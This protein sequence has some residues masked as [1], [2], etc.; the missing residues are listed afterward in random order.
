M[1]LQYIDSPLAQSGLEQCKNHSE[2]YCNQLKDLRIIVVSP[3][4]RALQ[5]AFYV[6]GQHPR[7]QDI[8]VIID[9]Y[10]REG[11]HWTCGIPSALQEKIKFAK[12]LFCEFKEVN[13]DMIDKLSSQV[14]NGNPN[15]W[16][17]ETMVEEDK[18]KAYDFINQNGQENYA[19][20]IR[21]FIIDKD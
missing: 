4:H 20:M 13:T 11:M 10:M 18:Q 3:L 15:L 19:E 8:T 16:F 7:R 21:D 1:N 12:E 6:L 5:T 17:V 2:D 9:P 14:Q